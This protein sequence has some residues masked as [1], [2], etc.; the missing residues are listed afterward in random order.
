M[1]L[2]TEKLLKRAKLMVEDCKKS[3]AENPGVQLGLILGTA[4]A[5]FGRDKVTLFC[6]PTIYDLGAWLEQLLA[7]STGKN[8]KGLIPV[9]REPLGN[10]DDYGSDRLFV[11]IAYTKDSDSDQT[12][13][14]TDIERS[15]QPVVRLKI[16]D[17]YD[18]GQ[19]FF[20]WEI[21]TAVAGSVLGINA[22]DQP[23]VEASKNV[24]R[25]LTTAFEKTGSLPAEKPILEQDDIKLFTDSVNAEALMKGGSHTLGGVIRAHLDRIQ[26]GDYFALLAYIPMFPAYE[27]KLQEIARA[28]DGSEAGCHRSRIRTSI[29]SFHGASVQ[30][31][32]ELRCVCADHLRRS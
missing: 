22:F 31:W 29:P 6:S 13:A 11:H 5:K 8:G 7:E 25:E 23:D 1:G 10:P 32:T 15:G 3:V 14:I 19:A 4:A 9:D 28:R 2:D 12:E 27:A 18:L 16:N 26:A 21:A 24:T 20:Q 30:G 17:L